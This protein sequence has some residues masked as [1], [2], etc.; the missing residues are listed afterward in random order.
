MQTTKKLE[1]INGQPVEVT[2]DYTIEQHFQP[3]TANS[4]H[5]YEMLD[6]HA[7]SV[8]GVNLIDLFDE[9]TGGQEAMNAIIDWAEKQ[10][11]ADYAVEYPR[12]IPSR[13]SKRL[14]A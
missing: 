10:A 8:G 11:A 1:L 5:E 3:A 14:A 2:I 7:V 4:P 13:F 6:I 9:L 12:G